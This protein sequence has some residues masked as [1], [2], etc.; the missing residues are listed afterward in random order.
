MN[1]ERYL[2]C[3]ELSLEL[4][5]I[6]ITRSTDYFRAMRLYAIKVGDNPF[7]GR[8]ARASE[9]I[10]WMRR[11]PNFTWSSTRRPKVGICQL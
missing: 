6:G 3:G 5:A 11:H 2:T 4:S 1:V 7:V 10:E 8:V 9:V